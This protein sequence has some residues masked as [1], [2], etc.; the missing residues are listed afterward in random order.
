[1]DLP[2]R[3]PIPAEMEKLA[4][5]LQKLL[6]AW[7]EI[8]FAYVFGSFA[9]GLPYHDIDVALFLEPAALSPS[10]NSI[11]RWAFRVS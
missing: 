4:A 11:T 9:A 5:G 3:Q 10:P 8:A 1:M 6:A 2:A 7:Q